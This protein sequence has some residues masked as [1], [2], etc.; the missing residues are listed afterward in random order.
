[1]FGSNVLFAKPAALLRS[2]SLVSDS[3]YGRK[4]KQPESHMFFAVGAIGTGLEETYILEVII[5]FIHGVCI[6]CTRSLLTIG[7][8]YQGQL[9]FSA[10]ESLHRDSSQRFFVELHSAMKLPNTNVVLAEIPDCA[11]S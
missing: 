8:N 6:Y 11:R 10:C 1:M 2:C 7:A 4:R 9:F 5:K 3:D